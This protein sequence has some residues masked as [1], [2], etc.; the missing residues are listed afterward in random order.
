M[1]RLVKQIAFVCITLLSVHSSTAQSSTAFKDDELFIKKISDDIF[2]N[3]EC[4][5]NLRYLCKKIG[6]RLSGSAGM[7]K[8]EN[9]CSKLI[10]QYAGI[11][12]LIK[13]KTT[14]PYWVRGGKDAAIIK[15][16]GKKIALNVTALGNSLG[17]MGKDGFIPVIAF[18]DLEAFKANPEAV[19]NKIVFFNKPF[20]PT[21][22]ET[23][24]AYGEN[25]VYRRSGPSIIAKY[26]A[27][28]LLIQSLS[29]GCDNHPH[30]G[31][32]LYVD[33][34]PKIPCVAL[35][36]E[37]AKKIAQLIKN[38]SCEVQ[39]KTYGYYKPDTIAHNIIGEIKGS[40][41][42]EKI[43]TIG[44]HLDSWDLA[45][46]AHDDGTGIMQTLEVLRV[47]KALGYSPKH[48]IRFVCFANEENGLRGARTYAEQAAINKEQHVFALETDAGGFTPRGFGVTVPD[49][50]MLA[51]L[52]QF[53]PLLEPYGT[54]FIRN[55]GGGAD[56]GP[57]REKFGTTLIGLSPDSQRYFD[58]HHAASDVFEAVN[59]RELELGAINIA[60]FIYL[61]DKYKAY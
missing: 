19:H 58:V 61:I 22:V 27:K 7:Y 38:N 56:I 36:N 47:Y 34:F 9:Y 18:N 55:G 31:S 59:K 44:G 46:G 51:W 10:V 1:I 11:N 21:H 8:A 14:I 49:S 15:V 40:T 13:Q 12:A 50:T 53:K 54:S 32:T 20:N 6:H 48:T 30:T 43:I 39:I 60:A 45:E 29:H 41:Y 25:G 33:S 2:V 42:P 16:N 35:G 26:G 52:Q 5:E 4:Y 24:K 37:D 3:G 57:L 17:N 23:F 28:G